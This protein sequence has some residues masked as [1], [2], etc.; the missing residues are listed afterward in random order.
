MTP[1]Q[2]LIKVFQ[3]L[4]YILFKL[5]AIVLLLL[6]FAFSFV[7]IRQT[8][9]MIHVVEAQISSAI[10]AI[11]LFHFLSSLFVL[12]WAIIFI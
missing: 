6:H 11:A 2:M 8:K 10:Y 7:L 4:P 12:I 3:V 1:E 5:F 9:I